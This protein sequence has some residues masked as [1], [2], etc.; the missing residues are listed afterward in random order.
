MQKVMYIWDLGGDY[1]R[2]QSLG[3]HI[4]K[5]FSVSSPE[6][7]SACTLGTCWWWRLVDTLAGT[8]LVCFLA[9]GTPLASL[10]ACLEAWL[11]L[12]SGWSLSMVPWMSLV[13]VVSVTCSLPA[14]YLW[15]PSAPVSGGELPL[16][17][18]WECSFGQ[19]L[20]LC[21]WYRDLCC[22][23]EPFTLWFLEWQLVSF[24]FHWHVS[25]GSLYWNRS[26]S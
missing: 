8:S 21:Q 1:S 13:V 14:S 18:D 20:V 2:L 25:I 3:I 17:N 23:P 11:L 15:P 16:K 26:L 12:G 19:L 10:V 7:P 22:F 5:Y 9:E 4:V 6:A 24:E